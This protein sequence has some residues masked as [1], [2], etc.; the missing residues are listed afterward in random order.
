MKVVITGKG[1]VGKTT[2]AGALVRKLA[3]SGQQVVAVDAD[4][5]PNLGISVGLPPATAEGVQPILNA[6]LASG[7]THHDPK[8]PAEELLARYGIQAPDGVVLVAT[9]MVERP[10]DSCLCCGSH[11]TTRQFFSDLPDDGRIVVADLEAGMNDFVWTRPG[12]DDVVMVV[13]DGSAKA[14][15]IGRRACKLANE[16]GVRCV[17]GIA[18][19]ATSS[20]DTDR[21]AEELGVEVLG[22]PEDPAVE[23]ADNAG[24][25]PIDVDDTSPAMVAVDRL[26]E[27]L[28]DLP[29]S[30]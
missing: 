27:R 23:N 9:G 10:S 2:I 15:E 28:V 24:R 1:G 19:R 12:P 13:S 14:I 7:H 25:A 5:N 4:V 16:L 29:R 3:R 6:L 22:V 26:A 20:A 17:I 8:I 21:L 18:N 11:S 30:G